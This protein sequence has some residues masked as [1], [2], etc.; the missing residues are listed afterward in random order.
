[1]LRHPANERLRRALADGDLTP[2]EFY[3]Q[4]LRVVYRMLFL[5]VAEERALIAAAPPQSP[6][7]AGGFGGVR[8]GGR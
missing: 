7:R 2:Q 4:A 1:L 8:G 3:R 6:P 5:M